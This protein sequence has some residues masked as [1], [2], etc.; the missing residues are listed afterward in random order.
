MRRKVMAGEPLY[1]TIEIY[2][3]VCIRCGACD[4]AC[5]EDVMRIGT[6]GYPFAKYAEDCQACF[7]CEW[8]CPVGAIKI[9]VHKWWKEDESAA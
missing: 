7:L 6:D 4:P 1:P 8:D 3:E 5:P 2:K 9:S